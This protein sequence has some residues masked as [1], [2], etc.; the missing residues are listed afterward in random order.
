MENDYMGGPFCSLTVYDS[1]RARLVTV[2]GYAYAP[3]F[4]KREYV[5]QI[6]AVV[7]SLEFLP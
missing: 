1:T 7:R 6:E 3:Y 5:R 4:D 2:E